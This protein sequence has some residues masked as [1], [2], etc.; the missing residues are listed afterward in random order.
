MIAEIEFEREVLN[1][2]R[3]D[4][5]RENNPEHNVPIASRPDQSLF[6]VAGPGSGKTTVLVLKV[7]KLIFVDDIEPSSILVTTY[8]RKAAFE[9]RSRI[10]GWGD[11]LRQALVS[12]EAYLQIRPE[13]EE[14]D[15][16]GVKT[17]TLDSILEETLGDNRDPGTPPPVVIENFV[18]NSLMLNPGLFNQDRHNNVHLDSYLLHLRENDRFG[19]DIQKKCKLLKDL[20]DRFYHDQVNIEQ[21]RERQP[22]EGGRIACDAIADY[23]QELENRLLFDFC[24]LENEFLRQLRAGNLEGFLSNIRF[25][26]IDEYQ[27]T[28]L[29]QEQI[30]FGLGRSAIDN[31]GS[32]TVVGDDDQSLYRFRGATVD[33]FRDFP[34]RLRAQMGI[35]TQICYLLRNYRSTPNIVNFCNQFILL[36]SSFQDARV[37]GK[38]VIH[39]SRPGT[40]L[41]YPIVGIFRNNIN[42]LARDL[43]NFINQVI[44]GNGYPLNDSQRGQ[45]TIRVNQRNGSAADIAILCSSP[46]ELGNNNKTRLPLLLRDNLGQFNPPISI[47][48]PRGQNLA[49][50]PEVM[51]LCGLVL[52]CIDPNALVQNR[53]DNLPQNAA[54]TFQNWRLTARDYLGNLNPLDSGNLT[55]F[56]RAWQTREPLR[57]T[58]W[59]AREIALIDLIYK[60]VTWIPDMQ[61]DIEGLVYLEAITR[62]ITQAALFCDFRATIVC[63]RTN[64]GLEHAS[65]R[66]AIRKIF[67]PIALGAIEVNE[68][69]LDTLSRDRVNIMSIHQAKGLEFPLVIVDV[70]SEFKTDHPKQRFKRFPENGGETCTIEND[71]RPY[72]PL[73]LPARSPRDRAFDDLIRHYFVAFSRAQDLLVLVGLNSVI[74]RSIPNVAIGWDRTRNW[75]WRGLNNILCI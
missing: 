46:L 33:L 63:D 41:N 17:G 15:F 74:S 20:N 73:D 37:I 75:H 61:D 12:N 36:D 67:A 39:P 40:F 11:R 16:N 3:R 55:R 9:L 21:F 65:I 72:S 69:L 6:I 7:L 68:D 44:H 56:I 60:L 70:G 1:I 31:N 71:L 52:E 24:K 48:N 59:D 42:V 8:T 4:I 2:L 29:L 57:R 23:N 64:Q 51:I 53:I 43:A 19:Y 49:R 22:L 5:S 25:I 27:D 66:E 35:D 58:S 47:F 13:L 45:Y 34:Q 14:L 26:L 54:V 38:P 32:I 62:T 28:N 18:A 30:Y 10:L 50:I